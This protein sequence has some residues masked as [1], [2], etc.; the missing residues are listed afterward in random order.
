[1][2]SYNSGHAGRIANFLKKSVPWFDHRKS[3]NILIYYDSSMDRGSAAALFRDLQ[4]EHLFD[5]FRE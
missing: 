3:L 5:F 2:F 1:M 4:G